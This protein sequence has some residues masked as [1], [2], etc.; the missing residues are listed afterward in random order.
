M[1]NIPD[2]PYLHYWISWAKS[3]YPLGFIDKAD[4]NQ[5][6]YYETVRTIVKETSRS[7]CS[8]VNLYDSCDIIKIYVWVRFRCCLIDHLKELNYHRK[9]SLWR[10]FYW[11][12]HSVP[13]RS[14]TLFMHAIG[15]YSIPVISCALSLL[16]HTHSISPKTLLWCHP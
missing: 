1:W 3:N 15:G 13:V 12:G 2:S 9:L 10:H 4:F 14:R 7:C 5:D 11:H 6:Y 16:I 8:F